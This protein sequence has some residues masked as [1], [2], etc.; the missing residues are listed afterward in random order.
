MEVATVA[1]TRGKNKLIVDGYVYEKQKALANNIV[2]YECERRRGGRC[3][4]KLMVKWK[5]E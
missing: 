2:S 1:D 3:K 4:A 5:R